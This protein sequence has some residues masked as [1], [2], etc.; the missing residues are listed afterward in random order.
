[1][2]QQYLGKAD[3]FS[4]GGCLLLA[5]TCHLSILFIRARIWPCI[6][7]FA[8]DCSL[9]GVPNMSYARNGCSASGKNMPVYAG[10]FSL[11]VIIFW[12]LLSE[13]STK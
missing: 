11:R 13:M 3:Y 6:N 5:R 9:I 12:C 2:P 1:M 8:D 7:G 10:L 4:A